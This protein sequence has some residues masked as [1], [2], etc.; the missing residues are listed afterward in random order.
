MNN[1]TEPVWDEVGWKKSV[2]GVRFINWFG[3]FKVFE[4][5]V[6]QSESDTIDFEIFDEDPGKDDFIGR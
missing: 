3:F 1:T 4:F 2:L 6:E 5:V